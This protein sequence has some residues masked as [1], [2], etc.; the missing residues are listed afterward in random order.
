MNF[1]ELSEMSYHAFRNSLIHKYSQNDEESSPE[2]CQCQNE[3]IES[4]IK[5]LSTRQDS[6]ERVNKRN[7]D[8][9]YH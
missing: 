8:A 6:I 4:K 3:E 9:R 5:D 2:K 7:D 1:K